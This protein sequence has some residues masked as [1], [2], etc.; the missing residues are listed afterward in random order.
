MMKILVPIAGSLNNLLE[1]GVIMET[2]ITYGTMIH[3]DGT[4]AK[5]ECWTFENEEDFWNHH[6]LYADTN[7]SADIEKLSITQR[8]YITIQEYRD[9][10]GEEE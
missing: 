3:Y 7:T 6:S 8:C 9:A 2:K 1:C 4:I 5:H 10:K